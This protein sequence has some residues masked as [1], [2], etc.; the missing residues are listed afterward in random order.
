MY[1]LSQQPSFKDARCVSVHTSLATTFGT[2]PLPASA[3]AA[4][5]APSDGG[6]SGS[7]GAGAGGAKAAAAAAVAY[8]PAP[9]FHLLM[10]KGR[11][12]GVWR[13]RAAGNPQ[14]AANAR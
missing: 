5:S 4:S 14:M 9:G 10:H 2:S 1:Y 8:L 11:P 3:A 13:R 7:D 12:F 6:G